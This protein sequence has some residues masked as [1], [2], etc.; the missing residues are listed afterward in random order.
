MRNEKPHDETQEHSNRQS[1]NY[2]SYG[3]WGKVFGGSF[4]EVLRWPNGVWFVFGLL[5]A[6]PIAVFMSVPKIAVLCLAGAIIVG[7]I[8][9]VP[10]AFRQ[11]DKAEVKK[12]DS[13][14]SNEGN[15][16]ENRG[17][18][19]FIDA[20]GSTGPVIGKQQNFF[21]EKPKPFKERLKICL[22]GI[23]PKLLAAL[24]QGSTGFDCD[25][26]Q[27]DLEELQRLSAEDSSGEFITVKPHVITLMAKE[28]GMLSRTT[29]SLS[30]DLLK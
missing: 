13:T 10:V 7:T 26:K 29:F 12:P 9:V 5:L 14:P 3:Y 27:G 1:Q 18:Q 23:S 19:F 2:Y 15:V 16:M 6:S 11:I 30:P 24:A 28:S 4:H 21:G 25:L 8:L 17:D 20:R 22:N